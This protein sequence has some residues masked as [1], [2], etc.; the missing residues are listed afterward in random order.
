MAPA[1]DAKTRAIANRRFAIWCAVNLRPESMRNDVGFKLFTGI[2]HPSYPSS[3]ISAAT[4]ESSLTSVYTE[5]VGNVKEAIRDHR[6]SCLDLGYEGPFLGAQM[7]LTTVANEECI[8][9]SVSFVPPNSAEITRLGIATKAFPGSHTADDIARWLR[10]V[11]LLKVVV[12]KLS[13]LYFRWNRGPSSAC[14]YAKRVL[15]CRRPCNAFIFL[16]IV[17]FLVVIFLPLLL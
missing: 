9:L 10:Q 16:I 15:D 8:T 12:K 4:F 1:M 3:T 11:C 5:L 7:D 14:P 6:Q 13:L 17:C 2:L